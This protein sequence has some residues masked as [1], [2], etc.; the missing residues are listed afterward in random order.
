MKNYTESWVF[1]GEDGEYLKRHF[2]RYGVNG[3]VQFIVYEKISQIRDDYKVIFLGWVDFSFIQFNTVVSVPVKSGGFYSAMENK[4][5]T[6]YEF[7]MDCKIENFTGLKMSENCLYTSKHWPYVTRPPKDLGFRYVALVGLE[8]KNKDK[9][10]GIFKETQWEFIDG[11]NGSETPLNIDKSFFA[12]NS[13]MRDDFKVSWDL[14][15]AT[16][17]SGASIS[18]YKYI[19]TLL[20]YNYNE[21][22]ELN[23]HSPVRSWNLDDTGWR[24]W[25]GYYYNVYL[26]FKSSGNYTVVKSNDYGKMYF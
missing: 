5:G 10:S 8:Y 18:R 3:K 11:V 7:E 17:M 19:L 12:L 22:A 25:G 9:E 14:D 4:K 2:F 15:I 23:Y 1:I 16:T 26:G 6:E 24:E 13:T 21:D 20:E